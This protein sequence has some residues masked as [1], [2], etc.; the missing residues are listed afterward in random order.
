[1][2]SPSVDHYRFGE[3]VI[4]GRRYSKDV[5][6]FPEGIDDN[7][8]RAKGHVLLPWDIQQVLQ[9]KPEVLIVGCGNAGRLQVLPETEDVLRGAGIEI[10]VARTGPACDAYNRLRESKRVVAALHLTC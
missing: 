2:T 10:I 5:I 9:A 7:W 4:D 1:M 3:I 8:W 6:I